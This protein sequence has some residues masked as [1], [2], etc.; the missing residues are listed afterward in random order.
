MPSR[1]NTQG[2]IRYVSDFFGGRTSYRITVTQSKFLDFIN[3]GDQVLADRSYQIGK[4]L[5]A[6]SSGLLLMLPSPAN[7]A[8]QV[9]NVSCR[10]SDRNTVAN[11]HTH[12][13]RL[14]R[15]I[16]QLK[17]FVTVSLLPHTYDILLVCAINKCYLQKCLKK[18]PGNARRHFFEIGRASCRERV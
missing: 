1:H 15:R 17:K 2:S 9:T 12:V 11:D 14:I 8:T 16:K 13:E 7:G 3:P 18:P 5:L 6:K 10:K 4:I